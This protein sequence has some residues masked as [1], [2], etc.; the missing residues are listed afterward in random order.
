V[1]ALVGLDAPRSPVD[2]VV[3]PRGLSHVAAREPI[4]RVD[5]DAL[6]PVVVARRVVRRAERRRSSFRFLALTRQQTY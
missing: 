4:D 1:N 2:Q 5:D 3:V 6:V